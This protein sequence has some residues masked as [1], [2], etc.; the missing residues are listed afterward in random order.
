MSDHPEICDFYFVRHAPVVKRDGHVPPAD[1]PIHKGDYALDRLIHLLPVGAAWHI[2]PLLRARQTADLLAQSCA[3]SSRVEDGALAE[4]DFGDWQ[5]QPVAT[6]WDEVSSGPLH[7][8]S[9]VTPDTEPPGGESFAATAAR[10]AG[11]MD[12]QAAC[13]STNPRVVVCHGGVMRAAL[14]AALGAPLSQVIGVPVPHFGLLRLTLMDPACATHDGGAW[15][16]G[17][18]TDT[19]VC[20]PQ[21]G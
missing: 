14:A 10:V 6:V 4:M 11:W 19:Q 9:F 13:F 20:R 1:P 7:N 2:S 21:S 5:D 15:L 3:P 17:G 8:W 18:L 16:F 12:S